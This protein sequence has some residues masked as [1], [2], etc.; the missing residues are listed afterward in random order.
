VSNGLVSPSGG[1]PHKSGLFDVMGDSIDIGGHRIPVSVLALVATVAGIFLVLRAR[2]SGSN[3]VSAGTAA[4]APASTGYSSTAYDPNAAAISDLQNAVTSLAAQ[5]SQM[6]AS[7]PSP[8]S[9]T[10]PTPLTE[11]FVTV[12]NAAAND[13]LAASGI[14]QYQN[15]G[16]YFVPV[17]I[18]KNTKGAPEAQTG[19]PNQVTYFLAPGQTAPTSG[20]IPGTVVGSPTTSPAS[21]SLSDVN[22]SAGNVAG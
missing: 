1:A 11:N 15:I 18:G 6:Q 16:G 20:P 21:P 12:P 22:P 19:L 17:A 4:A 8:T 7:T 10:T 2:A 5:I 14:T 13:A 9:D 3:V